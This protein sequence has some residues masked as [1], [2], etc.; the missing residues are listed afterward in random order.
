M[1][2]FTV[3]QQYIHKSRYAR[4]LPEKNRRE[5]WNETVQRYVDYMFT[6][7]STGQGWTVDQNLKQEV[8]DAIYNL[9][10]MPSMRALMTAGKALDRDNVAGYN[11]SYL[12]IDDPK[13]FDEA[14]CILMNGTGVGFSVE[15]QY[16]NK[17]PEK[18]GRAHV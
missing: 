6:K 7:V 13:A 8:F 1:T 2:D 16:V 10:V 3:Y 11:C 9:E 4:F 18:I 17:L 14:M 12:P 5:H 15:R